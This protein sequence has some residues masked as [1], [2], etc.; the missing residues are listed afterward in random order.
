MHGQR[1]KQPAV[2]RIRR[3]LPCLRPVVY[4]PEGAAAVQ[5]RKDVVAFAVDDPLHPELAVFPVDLQLVTVLQG[6]DEA[7]IFAGLRVDDAGVDHLAPGGQR[8]LPAPGVQTAVED[9]DVAGLFPDAVLMRGVAHRQPEHGRYLD[10][11]C[12]GLGHTVPVGGRAVELE[13]EG[14]P[15]H[16]R[17][18]GR[19]AL[20]LGVTPVF[21][22]HGQAAGDA[23]S[24]NVPQLAL[25]VVG[26]AQDAPGD[27]AGDAGDAPAVHGGTHLL[28]ALAGLQL[29]G[30]VAQRVAAPQ[31]AGGIAKSEALAGASGKNSIKHPAAPPFS[32]HTALH[33]SGRRPS[34]LCC[35]CTG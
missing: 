25:A 16:C 31:H 7:Q 18:N 6:R 33:A 27:G 11:G 1:Q 19:A 35:K 22:G 34:A 29:H 17:R 30:Q 32:A 26:V 10:G 23:G 24:K 12:R 2:A 3:A 8:E 13:T 4:R 14:W 9:A 15:Q 21:S 28:V 5:H 20:H